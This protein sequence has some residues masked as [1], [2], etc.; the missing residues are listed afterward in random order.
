MKEQKLEN[1]KQEKIVNQNVQTKKYI[2]KNRIERLN[3]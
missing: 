1:K 2:Y 3:E